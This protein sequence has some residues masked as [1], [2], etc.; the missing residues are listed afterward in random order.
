MVSEY[1]L[2]EGAG[3]HQ[4]KV[5]QLYIVMLMEVYEEGEIFCHLKRT[6]DITSRHTTLLK[7]VESS[8]E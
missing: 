7:I 8:E 4:N 5:E 2:L 1:V 6:A 3:V